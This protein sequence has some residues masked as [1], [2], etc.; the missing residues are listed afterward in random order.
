[1]TYICTPEDSK[2][3]KRIRLLRMQ[4]GLTQAD[5]ARELKV[6]VNTVSGWEAGKR[7]SVKH[8]H[9]LCL[10]FH[11]PCDVIGETTSVLT[12]PHRFQLSFLKQL[13]LC[14]H[15]RQK[16]EEAIDLYYEEKDLSQKKIV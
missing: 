1:M 13:E 8:W 6:S 11:I 3:G 10:F 2:R 14:P 12:D 9:R 7:P 15:C 16:V 5:L 4:A